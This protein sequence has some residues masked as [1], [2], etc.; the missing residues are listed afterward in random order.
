VACDSKEEIVLEGR[1]VGEFVNKELGDSFGVGAFSG[2][3]VLGL[4]REQF[5]GE[6]AQPSL[7]HGTDDINIV[8]VFLFEEVD[9]QF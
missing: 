2:N 1:E 7:E 9:V 5:I 4:L 8:Q 6:F 3:A